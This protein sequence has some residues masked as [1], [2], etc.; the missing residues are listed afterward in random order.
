MNF[1]EYM[2]RFR[3]L[4]HG[5][6]QDEKMLMLLEGKAYQGFAA[7]FGNTENPVLRSLVL[8]KERVE[9]RRRK[10]QRLCE[11]YG[12]RIARAASLI[13]SSPLREY[14]LYYYLYGLTHEEIA[15]Q[16]FFCV[17]TVYRHGKEARRAL[18][19]ALLSLMPK[20]RRTKGGKYR[21]AG[22]LPRKKKG[23]DRLT[24]SIA[25]ST[26]RRKSLP[27]RPVPSY[28]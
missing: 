16:S 14:A 8:T 22:S 21:I 4:Q 19:K 25:F 5:V 9:A 26:A 28:I 2:A 27:Y 12:E 24:Q 15:E 17:R 6:E 13:E 18:E 11:R 20:A 3:L 1:D 23:V 10:R 7:R